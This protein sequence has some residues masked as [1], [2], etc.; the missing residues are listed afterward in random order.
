MAVQKGKMF[1]RT[2]LAFG[3]ES[4]NAEGI[5]K[6]LS[7]KLQQQAQEVSCSNLD[8]LNLAEL[9]DND[10]L[11]VVTST[12]GDGA[13]PGN[14]RAFSQQ[15]SSI[16]AV[17]PFQYAVFGLGDVGYPKFCQFG[18]TVDTGLA[19]K[20]ARRLVNRVDADL[21]YK[22]FFSRWE[23]CIADILEGSR[24]DG[25]SLEF[26]VEAYS[27]SHP[28]LASVN[29]VKQLN[30][31][32][33]Y[34][35]NLDLRHSG[36]NYRA[37]DLLHILPDD[38]AE[39]YSA[40]AQWFG[41]DISPL[42]GKELRILSKSL[43]RGLASASGNSQLKENL[44]TKNKS[45][46]A[47]YLY[48]RDLL[49]VLKDCGEPGFISVAKL[50]KLLSPRN[51]RPYLTASCGLTEGG[52]NDRV[53]ICVSDIAYK[54]CGRKHHGAASHP[55]CQAKSGDQFKVFVRSNPDF[56]LD[57]QQ[58]E[59][60]LMIGERTGTAPYLGFLQAL[61]NAAVARDTMLVLGTGDQGRELLYQSELNEW[62]QK[63]VLQK[64]ETV[65]DDVPQALLNAAADVYQMLNQQAQVYICGS[66][67]NLD[68]PVDQALRKII[69]SQS[70]CNEIDAEERLQQLYNDARI[71]KEL[72]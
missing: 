38:D 5:T 36:I 49:D 46:L 51:P 32:S 1:E 45:A 47:D 13:P 59:P 50:A 37:G 4:G 55:L 14:A 62:M 40:L 63:G 26:Q 29:S 41:E 10:L 23:E 44:K 16:R 6:R 22:Y 20:G 12:F 3:S 58:T 60:V 7:A 8:E 71:H 56:W 24:S 52:N 54:A 61:E 53:H 28:Y 25:L 64:L 34:Q 30:G 39:Q 27:A 17:S 42:A 19:E 66:K 43:L 57:T 33:V 15:L 72:Y 31:S 35:V 48:G 18:K 2:I 69:Q 11:L 70:G 67:Q 21:D 9:N 68:K 65:S